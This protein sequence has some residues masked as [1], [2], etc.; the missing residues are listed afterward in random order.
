ML[1][2]TSELLKIRPETPIVLVVNQIDRLPQAYSNYSSIESEIQILKTNHK[3][4]DNNSAREFDLE[5]G[6]IVNKYVKKLIDNQYIQETINQFDNWIKNTHIKIE[7]DVFFTTSLGLNTSEYEHED[8]RN[9][10]LEELNPYGTISS[11]LWVLSKS[12]RNKRKD[13]LNRYYST[14]IDE[15]VDMKLKGNSFYDEREKRWKLDNTEKN[16]LKDD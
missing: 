5:K 15:V 14:L 8:L 6:S 1:N 4:S 16:I 7:N 3:Y 12:L 2:F 9:Y 11:F 13:E 10:K